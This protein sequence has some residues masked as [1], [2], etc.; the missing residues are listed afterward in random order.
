MEFKRR[1]K[2]AATV[3]L[4]PMIDVVFQLVVF[5]MVSSTFILT[6]GINI[7]LPESTSSE[8]V[9]ASRL[10]LTVVSENEIYINKD[11]YSLAQL[12]A[13]LSGLERP[14]GGSL[15]LEADEGIEYA[16]VIAV[17]DELRKSGYYGV[18]LK[19]REPVGGE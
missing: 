3:D 17:L 12:P 1:L 9:A 16:L 8:A 11:R 6:P 4:I 10:V 2:T 14:E 19:T 13:V 18:N 5:F 7:N 15:V